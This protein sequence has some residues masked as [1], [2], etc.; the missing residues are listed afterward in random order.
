[1]ASGET[2]PSL[3]GCSQVREHWPS[4]QSSPHRRTLSAIRMS[5]AAFITGVLVLA[6]GAG[7]ALD[8]K[9]LGTKMMRFNL[10]LAAPPWSKDPEPDP[11]RVEMHR[12]LFGCGTAF[13][14]LIVLISSL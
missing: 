7:I 3:P 6:L 1:M 10:F 5:V 9:D 4:R 13:L 14:G 11:D 12:L 8:F 2:F